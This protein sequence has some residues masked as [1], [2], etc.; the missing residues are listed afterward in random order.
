[1]DNKSA[2]E[3]EIVAGALQHHD[4]AVIIAERSFGKGRTREYRNLTKGTQLK[5]TIDK[6]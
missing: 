1:M 3:S 4:Q 6:Y 2:S 5:L